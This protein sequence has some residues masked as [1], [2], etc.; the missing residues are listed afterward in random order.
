MI[1][2]QA[3]IIASFE[4]R[5][6]HEAEANEAE[7]HHRHVEGSGIGVTGATPAL[8]QGAQSGSE[9]A[10]CLQFPVLEFAKHRGRRHGA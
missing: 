9:R 1:A 4:F 8:A 6:R 3:A 2:D 5:I 10:R 7:K